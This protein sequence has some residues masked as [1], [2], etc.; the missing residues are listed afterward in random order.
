MKKIST[1]SLTKLHNNEH[2]QFHLYVNNEI[3]KTTPEKLGIEKYSTAYTEAITAE[4]TAIDVEQ[5]SYFTT[6]VRKKNTAR[7]KI[8][9]S[10]TLNIKNSLLSSDEEEVQS[11]E[12]IKRIIAQVGKVRRLSY[13]NQ[14]EAITSLLTQLKT[15]Y[16]MDVA[17][18]NAN[19]IL[20]KLEVANNEFIQTYG[21]R[22]TESSKKPSGNVSKARV[23]TDRIFKDIVTIVNA[24][25]LTT[26]DTI[27]SG[28][29]DRINLQIDY[30]NTTLLTRKNKR[31]KNDD[32]TENKAE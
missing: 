23:T 3:V 18:C 15:N 20:D 29:I 10:F 1:F 2:A 16:A 22:A 19:S 14:S 7:G 30:Y 13:H 4:Q 11:A 6:Y 31:K 24:R 8:Y 17:R 26:D 32:D 28:F 21:V 9:Y 12:R 25:I 5:G 27:V